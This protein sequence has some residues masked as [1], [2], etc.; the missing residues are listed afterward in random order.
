MTSAATLVPTMRAID[1]DEG[2]LS[3]PRGL[4]PTTVELGATAGTGA[5]QDRSGGVGGRGKGEDDD[6]LVPFPGKE[7]KT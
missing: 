4:M 7:D 2:D 5:D 6:R 1:R 3:R